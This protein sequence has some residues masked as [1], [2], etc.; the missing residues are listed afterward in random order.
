MEYFC[1]EKIKYKMLTPPYLS[2]NTFMDF[3]EGL[4]KVGVPNKI[5]R[6]V[7]TLSSFSG[8]AQAQLLTTL[9]YFHLM[10]AHDGTPTEKLTKLVEASGEERKTVLRAMLIASY[11]SLFNDGFKLE[12]ASSKDLQL[13][14]EK[15]GAFGGT[16]R[17]SVAFF[18]AAAKYAGIELSPNIKKFKLSSIEQEGE[19]FRVIKNDEKGDG[20]YQETL[21]Q[22][23]TPG[24]SSEQVW[25][26]K[27]PDFDPSW[28][29]D[30]KKSWFESFREL[31]K[32]FNKLL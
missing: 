30:V 31:R 8:A 24:P 9:K 2:F 23:Q 14:F 28:P 17:K 6:N 10:S 27:F 12:S 16:I 19:A 26:N 20:F 1:M 3:I 18:L 13:R 22:N 15:A 5:D 29:D 11:P 25:L 21:K 32:E 4:E 7:Q